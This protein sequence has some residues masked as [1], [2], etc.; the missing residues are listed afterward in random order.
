MTTKKKKSLEPGAQ[1][2]LVPITWLKREA[3]AWLTLSTA[4]D[5]YEG[6]GILSE[7]SDALKASVDTE[8]ADDAAQN[9]LIA[10]QAA[11]IKELQDALDAARTEAG[12]ATAELTAAFNSM[13]EAIDRL[14]SNDAPAPDPEPEP[15]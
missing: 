8:L 9:T 5:N 6:I 11:S 15:V 1:L 12:D 3:V 14:A 4:L 7:K 13:Q 2:V 10:S